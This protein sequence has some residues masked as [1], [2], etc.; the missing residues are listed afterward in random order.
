MA[1]DRV[2]SI[3]MRSPLGALVRSVARVRASVQAKLLAGFL[4]VTALFIAMGAVSLQMV[5][6]SSRHARLLD[7]AYERVDWSRQS[8]HALAMQMH[9][10]GAAL[11]D[12]G[13]AAVA[14]IL[15]ENN[16]FNG[17]LA[18]IEAAAPDEERA[19]IRDIRTAQE[20]VMTIVADIANAIRD[21]RT[22]EALA[23]LRA[24]EAPLYEAVQASV[25]RLVAAEQAR[26]DMLREALHEARRRSQVLL[27]VFAGTSILLALGCGFVISW[28]F[29]LPVRE[30]HGFLREV[31]AGNFSATVSV[32]NRD[33]FGDLAARMNRMTRELARFEGQHRGAAE[34]LRRV[35]EQ[36]AQASRAKSEFLANMSHELRTPLNAILGFTEMLI[37]GLYG[38]IPPELEEPL[39]D[40]QTNGRHLLRLINDVL[41][42][43]KIEAGR[44]ELAPGEYSAHE[45]VEAVRASLRSLAAEK[46][47]GL[48]VS[49]PDDLPPARGDAKR[50]SQCLMNLVGNAVKFT[51]EGEVVVS[52]ALDGTMLVYSVA[53]TGIGIPKDQIDRV[54]D[55]FRQ[56]DATIT[57]EYGGTGLGLTITRRIVELHGGR[58]WVES[59][60]GKGSTFSFAVPLRVGEES[61]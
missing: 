55:Q 39:A 52:V 43:S 57:R 9:F 2:A 31:A 19:I 24:R 56:V 28:S 45:V 12:P 30:T 51:H 54:F 21:G 10:T 23:A 50:L 25:A 34:E 36:L 32:P 59:E 29:V 3:V 1:S 4:L 38:E 18:R 15:R 60:P 6:A 41:D 5:A 33:E 46:G 40:I 7:E 35:N 53:D 17:M 49:A 58:I 14:R 11:L 27:G 26:M 48:R 20:G 13:E 37:D 44:M 61:A 22:G 16:R 47:L 42:L 8:E